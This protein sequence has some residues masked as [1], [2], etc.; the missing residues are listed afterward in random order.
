MTRTLIIQF[1]KFGLSQGDHLL[2]MLE[3]FY[4][5]GSTKEV[6]GVRKYVAVDGGMS[7]NIRPALYGAE[8]TAVTAN[9]MNEPHR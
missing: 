7:D 5:V 3:H 9:R 1:R 2:E 4:T 8:Y 6:P